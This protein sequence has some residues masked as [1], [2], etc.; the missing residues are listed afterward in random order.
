MNKKK[1]L[2]V[3]A[4]ATLFLSLVA[5]TAQAARTDM[6]DVSNHNG[7]MT[8]GNFT[9]MRDQYGVKS[10]VTKISEGT[11][12]HDYT[13]KNNISTAQQSGLYIN[14]YHFARWSSVAGARAEANYAVAMAKA[15]GLPI[16]AVLVADV[17]GEQQQRTPLNINNLAV[18]EFKRIVEAAGYRY[19]IYTGQGWR[20][21]IVSVPKGTGWIA[22]YPW[23]TSW[24]RYTDHHAWQWTSTMKF[25]GSYGNFD[26]SQL[27]DDFYTGG[28]NKNAVISN[29]NTADVD[30]QK[31]AKQ[32]TT[33]QVQQ[34]TKDEDYAQTGVFTAKTTLNVRTA[35]STSSTIVASYSPGESLTYDHVYIK[36]GYVW[37]RYMS[38]SG[39]YHYV[40]MGVMG[41]QEYG[42]RRAHS[43]TVQTRSYTVKF[44][45]SLSVIARK[46]GTTVS[47]L[48]SMNG[49]RN[50]NL[51]YPGQ[52]LKY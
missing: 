9:A 15:D 36:G 3:V 40:A 1:L 48:Q 20:D 49:I 4:L 39:S 5:P 22:H 34:A 33:T 25:N 6:V 35:P 12:Y 47:H 17:E 30:N 13:A 11:Y 31:E 24:D 8:V 52:T 46:L 16:N 10:V 27:Y 19:D 51:I 23:D 45:D 26:T 44:G 37:A 14:G 41:G 38:Y 50:A 32:E 29:S 7:Y 28:Q 18:M 2:G 43:A 21:T 42:A